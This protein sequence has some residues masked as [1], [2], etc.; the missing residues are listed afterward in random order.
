MALDRAGW[1]RAETIL[2]SGRVSAG[3]SRPKSAADFPC[4]RPRLELVQQRVVA[5]VGI[6]R[7]SAF[8]TSA[9][10]LHEH[11]GKG[12]TATP[13][14]HR[15]NG[16]A[17][18]SPAA[19]VPSPG[20][21]EAAWPGGTRGASPG[22]GPRRSPGSVAIPAFGPAHRW[23]RGSRAIRRSRGALVRSCTSPS[24]TAICSARSATA[25]GGM[26]V[27]WSHPSTAAACAM[28]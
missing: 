15:P 18:G 26:Y 7:A 23:P 8:S 22:R 11:R 25:D 14:A 19:P 21:V 3:C 16:L 5:V 6:P 24:S 9:H 2:A 10:D 28:L 13:F 20:P 1:R 17:R 12:R 27:S 4:R